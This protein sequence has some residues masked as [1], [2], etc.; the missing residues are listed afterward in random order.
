MFS[1][2]TDLAIATH[3]RNNPAKYW[4]FF[5]TEDC[6]FWHF[7]DRS[8]EDFQTQEALP[9]HS[10]QSHKYTTEETCRE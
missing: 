2:A 1:E 6:V 4:A 10:E 7:V 9:Q 5:P 3:K 8:R